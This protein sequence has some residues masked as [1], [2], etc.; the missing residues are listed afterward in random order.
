MKRVV[1]ILVA[2]LAVA[3]LCIPAMAATSVVPSVTVNATA[4]VEVDPDIAYIHLGVRTENKNS[5]TA[6]EENGKIMEKVLKAIYAEGISKDDVE[7]RGL[8]MYANYTWDDNNNRSISGYTV[9]NSVTVTVRNL[10]KV[11]DVVDAALAAGANQFNGVNFSLEDEEEY[12]VQ[13]LAAATTKAKTRANAIAKANGS[14]L[15]SAISFTNSNVSY[16]DFIYSDDSIMEDAEMEESVSA[17]DSANGVGS[18]IV[19]GQITVTATITAVYT[20]K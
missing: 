6:Q 16:N 8:S 3:M 20:L 7:T 13:A 14:S 5:K 11:G 4:K 18:T 17:A 1:S 2:I 15:G 19:A 10:D 12:Y 9:S